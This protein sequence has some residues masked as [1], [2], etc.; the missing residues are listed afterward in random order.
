[1]SLVALLLC[2][3][4]HAAE[5]FGGFDF[6]VGDPH[7]HTG[8][9]GDGGSGDFAPGNCIG[10]CGDFADIFLTARDNGLDWV[11]VSDHSNGSNAPTAEDW[12]L[13]H[14]MALEGHDPEGGFVTIPAAEVWFQYGDGH[15]IGHKNLLLFGDNDD[16][17]G[18]GINDYRFGGTSGTI[19]ID[20][21][22]DI[23]SWMDTLTA[24]VGDAILVPHHP[25]VVRPMGTDW[26]CH[27]DTYQPAVEVYS[28]HGSSLIRSS[29]YDPP[30]SGEL[31]DGTV[32]SAIDPDEF[33][34]RLGFLGG[35]DK[36]DTRP[37]G[38]CHQDSEHMNHPYGGGISIVYLEKDSTFDRGPLYEAIMARHS[39]AS[40]GPIVPLTVR[41]SSEGDELGGMGDEL[42]FTVGAGLDVEV[43]MPEDWVDTVVAVRLIGAGGKRHLMH[44]VG[45]GTWTSSLNGGQVRAYF[46]VEVELDGGT[47]YAEG[48]CDDGG[49]DNRE[50]LWTSP[51]WVTDTGA[52]H[53]R[54]GLTWA[55]G[56][57]HDGDATVRPGRT[58]TWY[59]GIDQ[60]CDGADDFDRDGDGYRWSV[61]TLGRDCDD[62]DPTVHPGAAEIW[63]DGIDQ[64]CDR[65]SDYDRDRDGYDSMLYGGNDCDDSS[66]RVRP[67]AVE[68]YYDGID[69][70]CDGRS[71]YDAD[72]DGQDSRAYGGHDP[73]D[74][75]PKVY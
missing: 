36:H 25:A 1:M 17:E 26:N 21:C 63:Y 50:F 66:R 44:E 40:T 14:E 42:A 2:S 54:D 51:S 75:D 11:A 20:D 70:D 29:S 68:R 3:A 49:D 48:E 67:G 52:D 39:Y 56:D 45:D 37:G 10:D 24:A 31:T 58:E 41:W 43:A 19:L 16:L 72:G 73:N 62:G 27:D 9:S 61:R 57:C 30:W 34:L 32:E 23:W 13:L 60:D 46:Y 6:Y 7:A 28:E 71:D 5:T 15:P 74:F 64:N 55:A 47:I 4:V 65:Q 22:D 35:S 12:E 33:G 18:M 69:Q 8:I 59:D 38:V 53:D